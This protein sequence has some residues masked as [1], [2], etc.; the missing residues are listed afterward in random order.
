MS[1]QESVTAVVTRRIAPAWKS[2]YTD[3]VHQ[4]GTV[5]SQFPGHQGVTYKVKGE[6]DE[7]HVVFRFDTIEH[8][9]DWEESAERRK[10]LA[11][12]EHMVEGEEHIKRLTGLEFLFTD[13]LHPK[14]YKM[15]LVLIMVI[16]TLLMVLGPL[17][18]FLFS[19]LPDVPNWL[20][21]LFQVSLLVSLMTYFIMPRV[22]RMLMPWLTR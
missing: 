6:Q 7:C 12:I 5:A 18:S 10:W 21:M 4:V 11:K 14:A 13:Q 15:V 8:L 20:V 1:E 3:W 19:A 22:T 17:V 9:R 16:F 2:E